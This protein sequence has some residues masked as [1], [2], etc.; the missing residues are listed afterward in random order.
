MS[1]YVI[2]HILV[3][4]VATM[5][6]YNRGYLTFSAAL[7]A[8][9]LTSIILLFSNLALGFSIGICFFITSW[10]SNLKVSL[11][12][13]ANNISKSIPSVDKQIGR[14]LNQVLANGLV[15]TILAILYALADDEKL[16]IVAAFLGCI[17]SVAGDTWASDIGHLS[18]Q[19]PIMLL[20]GK[21]VAPGTPGAVTLLGI[22]LTLLSGLIAAL[23]YLFLSSFLLFSPEKLS[24]TLSSSVILVVGAAFGG[25]LGALTDSFLGAYAQGIY[26]TANGSISDNVKDERGQENQY[27]HGWLWLSNNKVNFINSVIGS[28]SAYLIWQ[29]AQ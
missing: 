11:N 24:L 1:Q 28:I 27:I 9:F 18:K 15:L 5:I 4:L 16:S 3:A 12:N 14:D 6:A 26:Q 21:R 19:K 20:T 10:F 13:R 8:M 25:M 2:L 22:L 7:L 29:I 23:V 17:G